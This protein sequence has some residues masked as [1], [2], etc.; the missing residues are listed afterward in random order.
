MARGRSDVSQA[1]AG[2]SAA[3]DVCASRALPRVS[4]ASRSL[5]RGRLAHLAVPLFCWARPPYTLLGQSEAV[6]TAAS[7][8]DFLD[9]ATSLWARASEPRRE[10]NANTHRCSSTG[11]QS[12]AGLLFWGRLEL[13]PSAGRAGVTAPDDRTLRGC[14]ALLSAQLHG[15]VL[16]GGTIVTLAASRSA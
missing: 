3:S 15:Q 11:A 1:S 4:C 8:A 16:R 12:S 14:A 7:G 5:A 10:G 2:S 13:L 9:I 6:S